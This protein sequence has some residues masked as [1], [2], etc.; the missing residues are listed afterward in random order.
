[1]LVGIK[2]NIEIKIASTNVEPTWWTD[3]YFGNIW[4]LETFK[5]FD[6]YLTKDMTMLDLG[7]FEGHTVLYEA[8]KVKQVYGL[9]CDPIPYGHCVK[10]IEA[11]NLTN[12]V[13]DAVAISDR[14]GEFK[15]TG[16]T[17]DAT[18]FGHSGTRLDESGTIDVKTTTIESF[19]KKHG[20][21]KIDFIKM[22]IEG[23][24]EFVIPAMENYLR[25][26]K[27]MLYISYHP[28]LMAS[29]KWNHDLGY[30]HTEETKKIMLGLKGILESIYDN[31]I[32][33][34]KKTFLYK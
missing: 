31:V 16:Q 6:E 9:E 11:N 30:E 15:I 7:T 34:D 26:N 28:H 23:G 4:E 22:D 27:P 24:E 14:D 5:V 8:H 29:K 20:I 1:M 12:V 32:E 18:V 19:I 2:N 21:E 3:S 13:M 10:N 33:L 17:Y 25:A